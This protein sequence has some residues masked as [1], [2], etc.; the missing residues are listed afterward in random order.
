LPYSPET[1]VE[2]N[3]DKKGFTFECPIYL[4]KLCESTLMIYVP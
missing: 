1:A 2:E 4:I 3:N